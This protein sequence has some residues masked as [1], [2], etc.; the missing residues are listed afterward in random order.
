MFILLKTKFS[1][2]ILYN[3]LGSNVLIYTPNT[4]TNVLSVC[5]DFRAYH[6]YIIII[7]Y[8]YIV[9]IFGRKKN[10]C[11]QRSPAAVSVVVDGS[12]LPRPPRSRRPSPPAAKELKPQTDKYDIIMLKY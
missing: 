3:I 2:L 1:A 8:V 7:I 9:V 12:R 10:N 4:T 5:I 6:G 11:R